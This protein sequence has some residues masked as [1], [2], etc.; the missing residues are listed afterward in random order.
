QQESGH[1][2]HRVAEQHFM[3]MP[4]WAPQ[5]CGRQ[6]AGVLADPK[7]DRQRCENAGKQVER[8]KPEIPKGE[9]VGS[10]IRLRPENFNLNHLHSTTQSLPDELARSVENYAT[11]AC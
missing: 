8:P 2:R 11:R 4:R 3:A 1:D 9:R 7:Q 6:L 5:I 10:A